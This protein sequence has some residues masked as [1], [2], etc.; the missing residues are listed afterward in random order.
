MS[1]SEVAW[2]AQSAAR[3]AADRV[4][5]GLSLHRW[6]APPRRG[7]Y[8]ARLDSLP[9]QLH[10]GPLDPT[11]AATSQLLTA[12]DDIIAHRLSFLNLERVDLGPEIDWNR[13]HEA[14]I[15][16]PTGYAG[17]IDY[18]DA[19]VAGDAKIVWEP[20][21]HLHLVV[22]GR[23]Y[24]ASGHERY[25]REG[26]NQIESWIAQCPFGT[27][28]QWRSPLE[29]AIRAINWTW[30][31]ALVAPSGLLAGPRLERVLQILDAHVYD[32]TRKYSRGS[33][34]NNHRIGEACGVFVAC[35][36]LPQLTDARN[37]AA[38]SA[39][40]LEE[41]MLAQN[42]ADGG[43]REQAF[44]YHLFVLQ[45]LLIAAYAARC[46]GRGMSP[47]YMDR[48]DK[49]VDFVDALTA[50]GPAPMYGDSD[51]GYVLDLG[52]RV[53]GGREWLGVGDCLL[54]RAPR[55]SAEPVTWL[56][57]GVTAGAPPP[58][59]LTS[60]AFPDT[61]LYLLQWGNT[62][63][64]DAVSLIFDCGPLGLGPLA[65]HG[66]ADALSVTLR[67][68][69]EDILVDPGTY[70]Y[71]RFPGWRDY[72]RSTRAHNTIEVDGLDQ[73]VM[74]GPFMWG[75]RANARCLEWTHDD[76]RSTVVG[77]HDGYRRLPDPV[78][79]RRAVSL[80]IA[81]RTF[82]IRDAL[83]MAAP[84][85]IAI[86]FHVSERASVRRVE[87]HRFE[88]ATPRGSV[89]LMLDPRTQP[90]LTEAGDEQHGG[91]VSR[92]YHRR[93]PSTSI[94]ASLE[95]SSRVEIE[96]RIVVGTPR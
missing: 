88:I 28:M 95:S 43:N 68:F 72:F 13:D 18:R 73:S 31:L 84:H 19:R 74:L 26:L 27:G 75:T 65:A 91:W 69:G 61:G 23:A 77:E 53:R 2:R 38:V 59:R 42:F 64:S 54:G 4:R 6:D 56:F 32:I 79:H 90:T 8:P 81:Q 67:A 45:F 83:T 62:T 39:R 34:A 35:S 3:D 10:G 76:H 63:T 96:T 93:S 51:D 71:F 15:G 57:P 80:D 11:S 44:G 50:A 55:E 5:I 17:A 85:R 49:M 12:A 52:G 70:D 24:R 16:A 58:S 60:R 7:A 89:E 9:L 1:A 46:T 33:S 29:L 41:E 48:L 36:C 78:E 22:L 66:H 82:T 25:A 47:A 94:A 87:P 40:I 86:A 92:G 37:R 20:S 30:F 14:G 21:R